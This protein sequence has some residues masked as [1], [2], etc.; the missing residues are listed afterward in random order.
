MAHKI[1]KEPSKAR[2]RE[3]LEKVATLPTMEDKCTYLYK[4]TLKT[5]AAVGYAD[6]KLV[7][8]IAKWLSTKKGKEWYKTRPPYGGVRR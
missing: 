6:P 2:V 5:E 1:G 8:K 7:V 4:L 3:V